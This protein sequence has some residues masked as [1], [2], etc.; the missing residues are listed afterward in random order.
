MPWACC[1]SA[2]R[3]CAHKQV[4]CQWTI[5][6]A[7]SA[8]TRFLTCGGGFSIIVALTAICNRRGAYHYIS[9]PL[10]GD[11]TLKPTLTLPPLSN[12]AQIFLPLPNPSAEN[13]TST[14]QNTI[15][16]EYQVR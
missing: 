1:I 4:R 7:V 9:V 13:G 16:L 2:I 15:R 8:S 14:Y 12:A 3:S 11:D 6:H 10:N 5:R